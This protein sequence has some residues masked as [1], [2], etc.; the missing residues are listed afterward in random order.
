MNWFSIIKSTIKDNLKETFNA[1]KVTNEKG[2][3]HLFWDDEKAYQKTFDYFTE[4]MEKNPNFKF[5]Y[6][7]GDDFWSIHIMDKEAKWVKEWI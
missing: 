6:N 4:L 1:K 7:I 2:L 5:R 3:W